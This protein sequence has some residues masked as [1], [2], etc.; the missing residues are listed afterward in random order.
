MEEKLEILLDGLKKKQNALEEIVN[1]TTNQQVVIKSRLTHTEI[2]AFIL[3]MNI[4][5]QQFIKI[6]KTC[7]DMFE[8]LLQEVGPTLD[9]QV[10]MYKPQVA[11][12]QKYIRQIMD[13]DKNIRTLEEENNK[14]IDEIRP[15]NIKPEIRQKSA[16]TIDERKV[17][18]AYKE[19]SKLV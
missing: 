19:G 7:D 9:A 18:K 1:I 12:L 4:E 10:N 2:M 11:D 14:L 5:K 8:R 16:L 6:V 17:L 15:K 13:L 3:E